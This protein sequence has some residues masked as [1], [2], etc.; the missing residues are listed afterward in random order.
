ML[1]IQSTLA[2]CPHNIIEEK[3]TYFSMSS[4]SQ[5]TCSINSYLLKVAN[6][7]GSFVKN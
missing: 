6:V 4:V 5:N 2:P 7:I 1:N 3:Y